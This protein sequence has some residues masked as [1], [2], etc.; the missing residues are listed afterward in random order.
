M[1]MVSEIWS[2]FDELDGDLGGQAAYG[3]FLCLE[4][5]LV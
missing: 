4:K 2:P 5:I 3:C 1:V